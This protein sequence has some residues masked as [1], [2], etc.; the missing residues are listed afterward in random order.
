M[1]ARLRPQPPSRVVA[2]I[3][4]E[5][6]RLG[7]RE[8]RD[9]AKWYSPSAMATYGV[10]VPELRRVVRAWARE[11]REAPAAHVLRVA[12]GLV[13]ARNTDARAAGYEILAR[14][15]AAI[16][17]L[18]ERRVSALG[19]GNDNWVSVDAFGVLVAGPAW[20]LGRVGDRAVARWSASRDRWWRRTALVATVALNARSRGGTGDVRRTLNLCE[21]LA[22]DRD[23]MVVKAL[24][25]ALRELAKREP[26]AVRLF[27][28]S[29]A[30][31]LAPRVLRE[32]ASK[33]RTGRKNPR[34]A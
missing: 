5:L 34:R 23:D 27:V 20:R 24:S 33:L 15:P 13:A 2:A 30:K 21:R 6:Q 12:R 7:R 1:A 31:T 3:L 26:G 11:L 28:E 14:H 8:R 29:H 19:R 16:A 10:A 22:L 17:A 9:L 18:D 4:A 32:V 25:W